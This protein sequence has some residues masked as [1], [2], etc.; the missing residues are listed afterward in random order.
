MNNIAKLLFG[1]AVLTLATGCSDDSL[2][3]KG[4]LDKEGN[5]FASLTLQL[6]QSRSATNDNL[7]DDE[8]RPGQN[9]N[10]E[11]GYEIGKDYENSVGSVLVVLATGDASTN[12]FN[13]IAHSVASSQVSQT[14]PEDNARVVYNV[15]FRNEDLIEYIASDNGSRKNVYVFAYCNPTD[16]LKQAMEANPGEIF[17][18]GIGTITDKDNAEIWAAKRFLMSNRDLTTSP[19]PTEEEIIETYNDAEHPFSLGTVY[20]ERVS[21]RFDFKETTVEGATEANLYPVKELGTENVMANVRLNAMALFNLAKEYYYLPRTGDYSG[22]EVAGEGY[23]SYT[24]ANERICGAE[25]ST[26]WMLSPGTDWKS[27]PNVDYANMGT[28]FFYAPGVAD[29][30]TASGMAFAPTNLSFTTIASLTEDQ[31]YEGWLPADKRQQGYKIWRY[32]TENTLPGVNNQIHATTTGVCFQAFL[33]ATDDDSNLKNAIDAHNNIFALEGTLYG[34]ADMVLAYI[35]EHPVCSL[36]DEWLAAGG[37]VD[38]EAE[39][40]TAPESRGES[41][42]T[43]YRYDAGLDGYPMYYYYYNRHND[44][45]RPITMGAMEFATVRNNIYKLAVTNVKYLGHPGDPGDD[46]DPEDPDDPDESPKTYFT[47]EIQVLP[48]VVRVNNIVF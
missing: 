3:S 5:V 44:N 34:D 40:I 16:A 9:T 36:L 6:S 11:D 31:N 14:T 27:L 45:D 42:L 19:L 8:T 41:N 21:S 20:V 30:E 13:Y 1:A 18:N 28:H 43:I 25:I 7:E 24:L 33:E 48:W 4:K 47:V 17:P 39:Q 38:L 35:K 37:T 2:K 29:T 10:S 12:T 32:A 46:P 15:T 22:T 23:T 26:N